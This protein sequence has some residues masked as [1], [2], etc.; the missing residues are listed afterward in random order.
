MPGIR[1]RDRKCT[2]PALCCLFVLWIILMIVICGYAF[3]NGDLDRLTFKFDMDLQNC[4]SKYN[5]KLF[6]RIVPTAED[7][8]NGIAEQAAFD[9]GTGEFNVST[10]V[11]YA[12]C[13]EACPKL[14]EKVSW[15]DNSRYKAKSLSNATAK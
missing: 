3:S 2:D 10:S 6:T 7:I 5:K 1:M 13:V 15:M 9:M 4:T 11:H 14:N 8:T 12:V